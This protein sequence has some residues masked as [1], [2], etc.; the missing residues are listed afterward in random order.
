MRRK[1]TAAEVR[2]YKDMAR[3]A[4]RL[5]RAMARAERQR[6]CAQSPGAKGARP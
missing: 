5:R 3:V 1:L 2:A 4:A 6:E